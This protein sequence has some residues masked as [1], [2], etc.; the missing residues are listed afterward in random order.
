MSSLQHMLS[1]SSLKIIQW[2]VWWQPE[3][4]NTE[5]SVLRTLV[6]GLWTYGY[7]YCSG[8]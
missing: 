8:E 4:E 7:E 5:L 2:D 6:Y 1:L 3:D